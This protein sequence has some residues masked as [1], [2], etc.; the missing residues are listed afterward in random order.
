MAPG[1]AYPE[2]KEGDYIKAVV[3]LE[4]FNGEIEGDIQEIFKKTGE[5]E[6]KLKNE[7]EKRKRDRARIPALEFLVND[8]ILI[9]LKN[10]FVS[11]ATEIR[12]AIFDGRPIIIRHHCDTDG[13]SAAFALKGQFSL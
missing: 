12:M 5:E 2:I 10:R 4:E 13:Y 11:A 8:P 1:K 9:K 3:S 6:L 7:I